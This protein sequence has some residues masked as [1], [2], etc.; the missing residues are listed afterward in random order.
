MQRKP[1]TNLAAVVASTPQTRLAEAG[2]D[3]PVDSSYLVP[4]TETI[5]HRLLGRGGY[6]S[7]WQGTH[8]TFG[9]VALKTLHPHLMANK[10]IVER[11]LREHDILRYVKHPNI[12]RVYG[13]GYTAD[14]FRPYILFEYLD[15]LGGRTALKNKGRL[16]MNHALEI[17]IDIASALAALHQMKIVHGDVKPENI[18]IAIED[19]GKAVPKLIDFGVYKHFVHGVPGILVNVEGTLLYIAPESIL[20]QDAGPAGDVYSFGVLAYELITGIRPTYKAEEKVAEFKRNMGMAG[21]IP[22]FVR[23]AVL[24]EPAPNL[25]DYL[26]VPPA[27]ERLVAACLQKDPRRR[28]TMSQA[29][30]D[31]RVAYKNLD[32]MFISSNESTQEILTGSVRALNPESI[33]RAAARARARRRDITTDEPTTVSSDAT[34]PPVSVSR[35]IQWGVFAAFGIMLFLGGVYGVARLVQTRDAAKSSAPA[36]S[37]TN[38]EGLAASEENAKSAASST[39]PPIPPPQPSSDVTPPGSAH[40]PVAA[41]LATSSPSASSAPKDKAGPPAGSGSPRVVSS[42]GRVDL[43]RL[44]ESDGSK[45]KAP[46][47]RKPS[48]SKKAGDEYSGWMD[49]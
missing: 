17:L 10:E 15:G 8:A 13:A 48:S 34:S 31:L 42:Q 3:Y 45:P 43:E 18:Y 36:P 19:S 29:A 21:E 30:H 20:G 11:F 5:I 46:S 6:G 22:D 33:Q 9:E 25:H 12:V 47:K 35:S 49:K 16:S 44:D 23:H 7:V 39:A 28:P 24:N 41:P 32:P 26:L 38:A 4:G 27:V 14:E 2:G 37:S 1:V 40:E